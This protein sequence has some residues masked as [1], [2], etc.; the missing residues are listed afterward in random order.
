MEPTTPAL[1]LRACG[2]EVFAC[3]TNVYVRQHLPHL[4]PTWSPDEV[5]AIVLLQQAAVPLGDVTP[6]TAAEKQRLRREFISF[7]FALAFALQTQGYM[8]EVFDP[9]SAFPLLSPPGELRH[10]DVRAAANLP[11]MQVQPGVCP[12]L[13]HPVWGTAV[14]PATILTGAP[15]PVCQPVLQAI[16]QTQGWSDLRLERAGAVP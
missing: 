4:V 12:M 1:C 15:P 13:V 3:A 6:T 16:A 10:N 7:G 8:T 2:K 9:R 11:A 14:Y 5:W